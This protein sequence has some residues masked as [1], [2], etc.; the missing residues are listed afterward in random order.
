MYS[1][2]YCSTAVKAFSPQE[3]EEMLLNFR[4]NNKNLDVT[5][6]LLYDGRV[7]LMQ[8]IE[9]PELAIKMLFQKIMTDTRHHSV[10][11]LSKCTTNQR[12][13]DLW[14]MH[15]KE[16]SPETGLNNSDELGFAGL[17]GDMPLIDFDPTI[18]L[19][20]TFRKQFD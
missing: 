7:R 14:T 17:F 1:L 20:Q 6:A 5:G 4:A 18:E 13:F 3:L 15:Y 16:Y 19:A 8:A 2:I 10:R 9:G 12:N 11:V